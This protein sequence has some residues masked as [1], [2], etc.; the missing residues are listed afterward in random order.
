MLR[1]HQIRFFCQDTILDPAGGVHNAPQIPQLA[2]DGVWKEK[3]VLNAYD[4][5][6]LAPAVSHL[7]LGEGNLG[8]I[9]ANGSV[10][11]QM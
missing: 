10:Y 4:A 7:E 2:G 5:S 11:C 6:F 1:M 9:D 3:Y 8:G